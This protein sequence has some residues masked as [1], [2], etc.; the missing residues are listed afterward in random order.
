MN[1]VTTGSSNSVTSGKPVELEITI[2]LDPLNTILLMGTFSVENLDKITTGK[3]LENTTCTLW[4]KTK[5]DGTQ[6]TTPYEIF[7]LNYDP[8][9][10]SKQSI[11]LD[12]DFSDSYEYLILKIKANVSTIT[13]P[14]IELDIRFKNKYDPA[15]PNPTV[16][17][18]FKVYAEE[19]KPEI[20]S[21]SADPTVL[22]GGYGITLNLHWKA[23][24]DTYILREGL[25]ELASGKMSDTSMPYTIENVPIGDHSYTLEVKRGKATVTQTEFARAL[26]LTVLS[27]SAN[28]NNFIIGNFIIGNK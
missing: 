15:D 9:N 20:L 17:L 22:Q 1:Y 14:T 6:P 21:F 24:G 10:P 19:D 26:D 23:K 7:Q 18:P 12:R 28:P 27:R 5:D 2:S 11:I 13:T 4:G 3:S 25:T 8:N 16:K